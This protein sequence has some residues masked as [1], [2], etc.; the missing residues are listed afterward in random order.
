MRRGRDDR[1]ASLVEYAL[2]VALIAVVAF[3]S[4]RFFGGARN[5]SLS[6]SGS[7]IVGGMV[8]LAPLWSL[9]S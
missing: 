3:L 9:S 8:S 2:L 7:A 4:L 6:R 5:N 1:G